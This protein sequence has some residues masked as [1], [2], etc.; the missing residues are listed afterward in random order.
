[1]RANVLM[2]EFS[3]EIFHAKE[4]GQE[5]VQENLHYILRAAQRAEDLVAS[6]MPPGHIIWWLGCRV[7][8][9]LGQQHQQQ[10]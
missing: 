3:A 10:Q 5:L 1:M 7:V 8:G 9:L 6:R 4:L 2:H